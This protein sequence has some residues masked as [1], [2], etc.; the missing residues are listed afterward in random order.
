[1]QRHFF[2]GIN[3]LKPQ[4]LDLSPDVEIGQ[5]ALARGEPDSPGTDKAITVDGANH[6]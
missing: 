3:L 4:G 1:V 5:D 6:K 2:G